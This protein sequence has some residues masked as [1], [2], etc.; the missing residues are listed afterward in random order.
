MRQT[1]KFLYPHLL[2]VL[3]ELT[4]FKVNREELTKIFDDVSK[5]FS[6]GATI[7]TVSDSDDDINQQSRIPVRRSKRTIKPPIRYSPS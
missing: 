6:H 7:Q 4:K 3:I 2:N 5:E 1:E